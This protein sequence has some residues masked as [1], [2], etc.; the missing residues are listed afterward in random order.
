MR[1]WLSFSGKKE[2]IVEEDEVL[3]VSETVELTDEQLMGEM[4]WE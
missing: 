1:R 2:E 3:K 4:S